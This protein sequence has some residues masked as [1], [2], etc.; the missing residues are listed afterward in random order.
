VQQIS[1]ILA[2]PGVDLAGPLPPEL[3][4]MT[5]FSAGVCTSSRQ[6]EAAQ[7]LAQLLSAPAG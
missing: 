3:Q 5:L 2:V 1:E 4:L 6:A 7:T